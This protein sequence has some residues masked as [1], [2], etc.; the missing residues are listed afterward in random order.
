MSK[1]YGAEEGT[2]APELYSEYMKAKSKEDEI[3]KQ[4]KLDLSKVAEKKSELVKETEKQLANEFSASEREVAR[5]IAKKDISLGID[6]YGAHQFEEGS[7]ARR[8]ANKLVDIKTKML[9]INLSDEEVDELWSEYET[10]WNQME[11][12][13]DQYWD[14]NTGKFIRKE[15]ASDEVVKWNKE[16]AADALQLSE[17]NDMENLEAIRNQTYYELQE[18]LRNV[19]IEGKVGDWKAHGLMDFAWKGKTADI[20]LYEVMEMGDDGKVKLGLNFEYAKMIGAV[21]LSSEDIGA[22]MPTNLPLI[23][24]NGTRA[25]IDFNNKLR[26]WVVTNKAYML[27]QNPETFEGT[28]GARHLIEGL[29]AGVGM[30]A[31]RDDNDIM[32][33]SF[34]ENMLEKGGKVSDLG[35]ERQSQT[36][37]EEWVR[38]TGEIV[39][40]VTSFALNPLGKVKTVANLGKLGKIKNPFAIGGRMDAAT[41]SIQLMKAPRFI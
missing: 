1:E 4:S 11:K 36:W 38:P 10:V 34:V 6:R 41:R 3:I 25:I 22:S 19:L 15:K 14:F 27:N 13:G 12:E 26:Q 28:S 20:A 32:I 16:V 35:I 29:G 24:G 8:L 9:D 31:R 33:R 40:F 5:E 2:I 30:R 37:N 23:P 7:E 39:G 17:E 21:S 18:A